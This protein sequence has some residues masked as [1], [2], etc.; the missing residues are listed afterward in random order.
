V[1]EEVMENEE[2]IDEERMY[3]NTL[4]QFLQ[5]FKKLLNH[6]KNVYDI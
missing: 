3:Q 1:E 2:G 5:D 6:K 4:H